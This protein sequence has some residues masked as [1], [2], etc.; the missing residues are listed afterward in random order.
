M[1]FD[2]NRLSAYGNIEKRGHAPVLWAY[3]NKD[4]D[5]VTAA[6]FIACADMCVG[7]QVLVIAQ[8]GKTQK[9][10]YVSAFSDGAATLVAQGAS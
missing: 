1:S 4:A 6:G 7:D 2:I 8:D 10:Y 9:S 5:T 3:H